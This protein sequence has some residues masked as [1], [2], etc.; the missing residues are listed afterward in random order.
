MKKIL[1][2]LIVIM[3]IFMVPLA[4]FAQAEPYDA[5]SVNATSAMLL[6]ADTGEVLFEKASDERI[7][8]ASTTKL[9]TA[10]LTFENCKME[11]MITVGQEV[12][13]FAKSSS[14]M[15]LIQNETISIKDLLYGLMVCSGN[16]AAAALAVHVG[17]TQEN[18]VVMMNQ[19]AQELGMA[20]SNFM[21][22]HGLSEQFK[23]ENHY[24]T[25]ADMAI[26]ARAYYK[27]P[28]L[29]EIAGTKNY[30]IPATNMS[31]PRAKHSSNLLINTP[32]GRPELA[33][34]LYEY[35]TG[36]KTGL[37]ENM[38]IGDTFIKNN[39]CLVASAKKGDLSLIA[40]IYGDPT[41]NGTD[42]WGIAKNLFEYGFNNYAK[43]DVSAYVTPVVLTEQLE[44]YAKN[45]PQQG[46][47]TIKQ[48]AGEVPPLGV[49]L[50]DTQTAQGLADGSIKIEAQ[51]TLTKPLVAPISEGDTMGQ[52]KYL[53][54]G[55][56]V[57][58]AV[59]VADRKVYQ[60][61]EENLA[62]KEYNL[63]P[64]AMEFQL[65]YLWIIIPVALVL[66][67]FILR[68]INK[69]RRRRRRYASRPMMNRGSSS[70]S[71]MPRNPSR[72]DS[73]TRATRR[74]L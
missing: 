74:K 11:D 52:V 54:D 37:T 30:T 60:T 41:P 35:A 66:A 13:A 38:T 68:I 64:P 15:G 1:I 63:P 70:R 34:Y 58:N 24:S 25:A 44:H 39:G 67:V 29:M 46:V 42:R 47:L 33:Q 18:F 51:T 27:I 9:L 56:E 7:Y 59:L 3:M 16:D 53:L 26:L 49:M 65:W 4:S 6:D 20:N 62:S 43:V 50:I 40:V 73:G 28:E 32:E 5:A 57:F 71:S 12:N 69:N 72:T 48:A 10:L 36:M 14:L 21:N 19:K 23:G 22:P 61:G 55:K 2:V 8:P 17:G 31:E 45:D